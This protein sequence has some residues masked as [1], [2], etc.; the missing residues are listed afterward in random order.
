MMIVAKMIEKLQ[1]D[2]GTNLELYDDPALHTELQANEVGDN[3]LH[4]G[5]GGGP[6]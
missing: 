4:D 2:D 3:F 1:S 6:R 5:K